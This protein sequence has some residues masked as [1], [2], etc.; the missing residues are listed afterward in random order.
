MFWRRL[1]PLRQELRGDWCILHHELPRGA[2]AVMANSAAVSLSYWRA[3][4]SSGAVPAVVHRTGDGMFEVV[5]LQVVCL[6]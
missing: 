4:N 6:R 5:D 1:H 3:V 2:L